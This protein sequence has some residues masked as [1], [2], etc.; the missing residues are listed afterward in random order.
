V[1]TVAQLAVEVHAPTQKAEENLQHLNKEVEKSGGLFSRL[2]H[3]VGGAVQS[4]MGFAGAQMGLT[5]INAL[6]SGFVDLFKTGI[7]VDIQFEH[8]HAQ[9]Q[10]IMGSSGAADKML[11]WIRQFG[12]QVPDTTEHLAEAVVTIESLGLNAQQV[13]PSLANIAAAMGVDLP[14]AAQSFADAYEGR[15]QMLQME[16]HVNKEE[17]IQYGLQLDKHGKVIGNSLVTSMEALQKAKFPH[18]LT[19]AMGTFQGQLSNLVDR[20]QFFTAAL[21][22]PLFDMFKQGLQGLFGWL[23]ANQGLINAVATDIGMGLADAI[24]G[25]GKAAGWLFGQLGQVGSTLATMQPLWRDL[26]MRAKGLADVIVYDLQPGF[27]AIGALFQHLTPHFGRLVINLDAVDKL[28]APISVQVE[29]LFLGLNDLAVVLAGSLGTSFD[30]MKSDWLPIVQQLADWFQNEMIPALMQMVPPAE[31]MIGVLV[32]QGIPAFFAIR[33]AASQIVAVLVGLF[34]PIWEKI[35]PILAK[36]SATLL[37]LA[38]KALKQLLPAVQDAA[39]AMGQF[40]S[41]IGSRL[42]PFITNLGMGIQW[43]WGMIQQYWVFVWPVVAAT[44][45]LAWDNIKGYFQ[46]AFDVIGGLLKIFADVLSGNWGQLWKDVVGLVKKVGGD[47]KG[48]V[49]T[50]LGDLIGPS[51]VI[52]SFLVKLHDAWS[53]IWNGL[54]DV[55]KGVWS[56]VRSW[57][58]GGV[59]SVIDIINKIIDGY[60]S[61]ANKVG[62]PT[63]P[64]IPHVRF[65]SGG[66]MPYPGFA[67]VGRMDQEAAFFPQGTRVIPHHEAMQ[68]LRQGGGGETH[69]HFEG[70]TDDAALQRRMTRLSQAEK[71]LNRH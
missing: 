16:L 63:I 50:F 29:N 26:S 42:Q 36:V 53:A 51:G 9:L 2:S 58:A 62:G 70:I 28:L 7:D 43:L 41:D 22:K 39:K 5:G 18:G 52:S 59:N 38:G 32:D 56:N 10:S 48:I 27:Q 33:D 17:L 65:Y 66:V 71:A 57:V 30:Q 4:M 21:T 24:T 35:Q 31:Q 45:K 68:A 3:F 20:F 61:I 23:D 6:V 19:D 34:L 11:D 54:G 37:D 69:Y 13:M 14:T 67:M 40:A 55:V 15:F 8:L 12:T 44:V 1:L 47:L 49:T 25:L 64:D 46:L 60:D